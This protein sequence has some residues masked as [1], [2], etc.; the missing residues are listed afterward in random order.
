MLEKFKPTPFLF[1]SSYCLPYQGQNT[2][3][4]F[5]TKI[6]FLTARSLRSLIS[7]TV[8]GQGRTRQDKAGHGGTNNVFS[9]RQCAEKRPCRLAA[10]LQFASSVGLV[11]LVTSSD[12]NFVIKLFFHFLY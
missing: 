12:R 4:F 3:Q 5:N 7:L 2:G 8:T 10:Q 6:D 11:I 9:A 1:L